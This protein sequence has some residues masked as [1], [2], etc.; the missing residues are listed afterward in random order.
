MHNTF[1]AITCATIASPSLSHATL[2][3]VTITLTT[4]ALFIAALII[5]LTLLS[6]VVA[7]RCGRV[8]VDALLPATTLL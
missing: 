8:V 2:I 7:C 5:C 4:L 6:F 3:V 1:V